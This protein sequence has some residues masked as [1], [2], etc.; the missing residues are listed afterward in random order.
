M[1]EE[2]GGDRWSIGDLRRDRSPLPRVDRLLAG[3]DASTTGRD[4]TETRLERLEQ[5]VDEVER[6]LRALMG[7]TSTPAAGYTLFMPGERGYEIVDRDGVAPAV[8]AA[9]I[10]AGRSFVVEGTRRSP[11]PSDARPC[12]VLSPLPPEHAA[13]DT[14]TDA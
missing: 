8:G 3:V 7:R 10:L 4:A 5:R 13:E 11:F 9:V 6:R 2:G 1:H 12:L 14:A